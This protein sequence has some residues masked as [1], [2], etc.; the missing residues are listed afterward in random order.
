MEKPENNLVASAKDP[1]SNKPI[2]DRLQ[3]MDKE[4]NTEGNRIFYL[5]LPPMLYK[6]VAI[7]SLYL[8][9]V[10]NSFSDFSQAS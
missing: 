1:A 5:A 3:S 7:R 8:L 4:Y 6:E 9:S 10:L 2:A